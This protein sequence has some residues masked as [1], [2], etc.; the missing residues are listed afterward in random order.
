MRHEAIW[1]G[2][3]VCH[4]RVRRLRSRLDS[5]EGTH[6]CVLDTRPWTH[7]SHTFMM[8]SGVHGDSGG[9]A[10]VVGGI[11]FVATNGF[12]YYWVARLFGNVGVAWRRR[13]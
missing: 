11:L 2:H 13:T 10:G 4:L 5:S 1:E 12:V 8:I 9:A 3:V 7:W 6:H